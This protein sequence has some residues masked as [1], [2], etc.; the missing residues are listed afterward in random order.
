MTLE[1]ALNSH[2]HQ[3][4][5]SPR[6]E[7]SIFFVT[8]NLACFPELLVIMVNLTTHD[9]LKFCV[10]GFDSHIIIDFGSISR[11]FSVAY[12]SINIASIEE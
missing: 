5:L 6:G 8:H 10:C 3:A 9:L 2:F 1:Y 11:L 7:F 4:S 12:Y